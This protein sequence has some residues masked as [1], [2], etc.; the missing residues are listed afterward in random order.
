MGLA[1]KSIIV[2]TIFIHFGVWA[3]EGS[4]VV[5]ADT[6]KVRITFDS[7]KYLA[8]EIQ[9]AYEIF[10]FGAPISVVWKLTKNQPYK[11]LSSEEL[12]RRLRE[13]KKPLEEFKKKVA[14]KAVEQFRARAI[15]DGEFS[16]WLSE[17]VVNYA[18]N[19][20]IE[21]LRRP[22]MSWDHNVVCGSLLDHLVAPSVETLKKA[23]STLN[24]LCEARNKERD[25]EAS[26]IC[27]A[28]FEKKLKEFGTPVQEA[29]FLVFLWS[30][31]VNGQYQ[32]FQDGKKAMNLLGLKTEVFDCEHEE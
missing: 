5:Q 2:F 12:D 29:P 7:E 30:N 26:E 8:N 9:N 27:R 4:V 11:F 16:Y 24:S 31:C 22:F 32:R 25:R 3:K 19:H 15:Q 21:E 13:G 23:Q 28:N 17:S 14:P 1:I 10:E 6:C 18:K 20:K